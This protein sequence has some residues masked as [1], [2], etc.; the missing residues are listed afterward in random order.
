MLERLLDELTQ[1]VAADGLLA[2]FLLSGGLVVR[3]VV[4]TVDHWASQRCPGRGI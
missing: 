1:A 2:L 4:R 3:L